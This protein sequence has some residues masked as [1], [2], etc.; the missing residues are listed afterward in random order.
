MVQIAVLGDVH[1]EQDRL[2]RV[3]E[4]VASDPPDLA[5]LVGDVGRDP[6]WAEPQRRKHRASHDD[7]GV[8]Q[9]E[10]I[11][12]LNAG[13][14]GEPFGA[15]IVWRVHWSAIRGCSVL[16]PLAGASAR[17]GFSSWDPLAGASSLYWRSAG[18]RTQL[19]NTDGIVGD[20]PAEFSLLRDSSAASVALLSNGDPASA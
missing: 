1:G 12:C 7:W 19:T 8:E 2:A 15:E 14:L 9:I 17:R 11:T 6:P 3:L 5:L 10:G 16:N 18:R 4:R 20:N 13:A